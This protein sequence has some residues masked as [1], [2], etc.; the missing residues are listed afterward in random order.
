MKKSKLNKGLNDLEQRFLNHYLNNGFNA[1]QAYNSVK[2]NLTYDTVKNEGNLMTKRPHV[3]KE[4]EKY[5][6]DERKKEEIKKSE[7]VGKLKTLMEECINDADRANLL[8]TIDILNKMGGHYQNKIDITSKDEKI[9]I[10][11][12]LGDIE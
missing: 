2:P 7:I 11:L 1:T 8:K 12:N 6:A 5:I 3:A 4:I 10:N 9:T